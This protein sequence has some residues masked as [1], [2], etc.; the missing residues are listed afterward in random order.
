MRFDM[1]A[2]HVLGF[3][4]GLFIFPALFVKDT[5]GDSYLGAL[6]SSFLPK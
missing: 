4:F 1:T 2:A 6:K 5:T 3:A